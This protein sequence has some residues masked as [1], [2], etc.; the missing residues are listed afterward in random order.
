M[1]SFTRGL[2]RVRPQASLAVA[3]IFTVAWIAAFDYGLLR[4][5][6]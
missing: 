1:V 5:V 6:W 3:L 4:L 2:D